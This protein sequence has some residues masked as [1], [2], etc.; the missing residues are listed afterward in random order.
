LNLNTWIETRLD[1]IERRFDLVPA[2]IA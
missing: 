2:P 1:R